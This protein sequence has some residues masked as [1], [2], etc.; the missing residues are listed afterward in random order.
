M[1]D[2]GNESTAPSLAVSGR[3]RSVDALRGFDM[4]WIVGAGAIV[5]ALGSMDENPVTTFLTTQLTHVKWEGFR[6]RDVSRR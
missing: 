5:K 3:L 1:S 4:F 6:F 2:S